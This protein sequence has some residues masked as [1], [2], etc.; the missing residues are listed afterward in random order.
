MTGVQGSLN[1]GH[2]VAVIA[3]GLA[4]VAAAAVAGVVVRDRRRE[5]DCAD[6][7]E[8]RMPGLHGLAVVAVL[9]AASPQASSKPPYVG[10]GVEALIGLIVLIGLRR[11][12]RR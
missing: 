2:L 9:A 6:R 8:A 4:V 5:R 11:W 3:I 7:P 10:Y 1:G 12:F